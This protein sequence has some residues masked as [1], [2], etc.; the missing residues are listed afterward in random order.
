M[1]RSEVIIRKLSKTF[2]IPRPSLVWVADQPTDEYRPDE[3]TIAMSTLEF[4]ASVTDR[5]L[6]EFAHAVANYRLLETR[7]TRDYWQILHILADY[8]YGNARKYKWNQE[9]K[10]GIK[11]ATRLELM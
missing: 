3:H 2:G 4:T 8:Q 9:Y 11:Y 10:C 6:H 5:L 7:H 1:I